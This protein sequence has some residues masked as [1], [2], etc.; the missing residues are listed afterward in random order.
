MI[1]YKIFLIKLASLPRVQE[2]TLENLK[3][4]PQDVIFEIFKNISFVNDII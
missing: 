1:K 3:L 2:S 4:S